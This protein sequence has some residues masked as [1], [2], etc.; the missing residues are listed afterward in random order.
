MPN[1][2]EDSDLKKL[3]IFQLLVGMC[4]L[5]T[6][7]AGAYLSPELLPKI[8]AYDTRP[9][10]LDNIGKL[11]SAASKTPTSL[12]KC[13]PWPKYPPQIGTLSL[14]QEYW[15][16]MKEA[17]QKYKISPYLIQA[18]CAIESRFNPYASSGHGQCFGLMQLHRDTARKYGVDAH[19]PRENI[20]GGAA[21]LSHLLTS[22]N[23]DLRRVLHIYNATCTA[24]YEREVMKAFVQAT[25]RGEATLRLAT[26]RYS[27]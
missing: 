2:K 16:Y 9:S 27:R 6:T 8:G 4:F 20:M 17:A 12:G 7:M 11:D 3:F 19:N 21:V 10:R 26:S 15:N 5:L 1:P 13:D 18:V 22:C 25:T 14:K 24:S 23:G